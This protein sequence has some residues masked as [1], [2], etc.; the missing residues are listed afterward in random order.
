MAGTE[1]FIH[2]QT[3]YTWSISPMFY[4]FSILLDKQLGRA[5][6]SKGEDKRNMED[7]T[8]SQV[9]PRGELYFLLLPSFQEPGVLKADFSC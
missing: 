7:K 1:K 5:S 3:A 6:D 8:E 2:L 4:L 9:V